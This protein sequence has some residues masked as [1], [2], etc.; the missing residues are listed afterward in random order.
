M[1]LGLLLCLVSV[2]C[3]VACTLRRSGD[4]VSVSSGRDSRNRTFVGGG[5]D[6]NGGGGQVGVVCDLNAGGGGQAVVDLEDCCKMTIC[7]KVGNLPSY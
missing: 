4:V 7:D 1:F 3:C 2:V 5:G 6:K